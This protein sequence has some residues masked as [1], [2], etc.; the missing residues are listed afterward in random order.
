MGAK[1]MGVTIHYRGSLADLNR[2]EDFED[3]VI[4][5][6][7]ALGGNVRVWRSADDHDR[8]RIV[9][10]LFVELAPGQDTTSFLI[11]PE[12]WFVNLFEI[13]D[14]E[15]GKLAEPSW[16][17][18]KTQFGPIEGHVALVEL[19][20]A[21]KKE[22]AP[23]LEVEDEGGYWKNRDVSELRQKIEFLIHAMD[24]FTRALE[25]DRLSPEARED[26]N[27]LATRIERIARTVQQ[28]L[29]RPAE[30]PPI[31]FPDNDSGAPSDPRENEAAW[32]EM[33]KNNRRKQEQMTR[34]IEERMLRGEDSRQAFD[35]AIDDVIAPLDWLED[36]EDM[37][38]ER[39]E[40]LAAIEEANEAC[41]EALEEGE[42]S[43]PWQESLQESG[44][45]DDVEADNIDS[46][47]ESDVDNRF[48]R[49]RRHPLQQQ[50][51][52]LLIALEEATRAQDNRSPAVDMLI[53]SAMEVTGGLAQVLPLSPPY[54]MD[55]GEA[56]LALV[57]L[58]RALRGVAFV[59]GALFL[60]RGEK[61]LD[62]APF[63]QFMD[64]SGAISKHIVELIRTVR[65]SRA[66]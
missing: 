65:E 18:V 12:G 36:D 8:S 22:F 52:N 27:I 20:D 7:L 2:V 55:D 31:Q 34:A 29:A 10:G 9:R 64:E 5:L 28:T 49:M 61:S 38:D 1:F 47:F 59:Q 66:P 44:L 6:A 11:S 13:E 21:I 15:K 3:R 39:R 33:F 63:K 16:C 14:A 23:N 48:E 60:L 19:L 40:M 41:R 46:D 45:D 26:P 51:T 62:D 25:N 57:Q 37:S 42:S 43:E 54:E 56:G 32:D 35:A 53:R 58:K 17:F 50:A 4:D 30:H 24:V